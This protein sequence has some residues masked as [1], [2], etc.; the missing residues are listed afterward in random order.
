MKF[1]EGLEPSLH[2]LDADEVEDGGA[3]ESLRSVR[4]E[5][6]GGRGLVPRSRSRRR[7]SS[8]S[9]R[10]PKGG[11]NLGVESNCL[12]VG[13]LHLHQ[14]QA[15][16]DHHGRRR[17]AQSTLYGTV[18]STENQPPTAWMSNALP[19]GPGDKVTVAI[20]AAAT[21]LGRGSP[22]G[23]G[24]RFFCAC[25]VAKLGPRQPFYGG[26]QGGGGYHAGRGLHGAGVARRAQG[27]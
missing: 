6:A 17:A 26:V 25:S 14:R 27:R 24:L 3:K 1:R 23:Y 16:R 8:A 10:V 20:L 19:C 7:R 4:Q 11:Y 13:N 9:S 22:E 15:H 21:P 2:E 18:L 12:S 5:H